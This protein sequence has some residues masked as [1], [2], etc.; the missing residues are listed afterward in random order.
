MLLRPALS[1]KSVISEVKRVKKGERVGY[2]LTEKLKRDS[3]LA[4][5]PV[6]YWH[7]YPRS[8]SG[9]GRVMVKGLR[10]TDRRVRQ[11]EWRKKSKVIGRVSMDMMVI[12]VTNVKGVKE[13][14][15]IVLIGKGV[16]AEDVA[17]KAGTINY[18][19]VTRINPLLERT[20]S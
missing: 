15:E 18:E 20:F 13:G 16:P 3:V 12:D 6:G 5:V 1:W 8:L 19:I 14:D 2:D 9:V 10:Q 11:S 7:G 4:I 17:E